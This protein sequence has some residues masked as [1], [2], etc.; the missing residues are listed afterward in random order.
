MDRSDS[1]CRLQGQIFESN[2]VI[3]GVLVAFRKDAAAPWMLAVVRRFDKPTGDRAD[4]GV[5]YMGRNPRGVKIT[6]AAV[7]GANKGPNIAAIYLP[8]SARQP[9]MPFKTLV[10]PV[11]KYAPNEHLTLRSVS[12]LYTIQLKEPI[13]EQGDFIW[14]PFEIVA[15]RL[16]TDSKSV[17]TTFGR[18]TRAMLGGQPSARISD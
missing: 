3:P 8:E 9:V 14:T 2:W 6:V 17:A 1:G 5:E 10:L 15:R 13:D 12:A 11:H 18:L 16:R 7:S 4:I